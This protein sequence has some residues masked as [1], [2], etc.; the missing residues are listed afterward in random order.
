MNTVAKLYPKASGY[1]CGP[2]YIIGLADCE[3][4]F[5][6]RLLESNEALEVSARAT[7]PLVDTLNVGDEVLVTGD[8]YSSIYVT[9]LLA[10]KDIQQKSFASNELSLGNG[11]YAVVDD[12]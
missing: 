4:M 7:V 2:A 6:I 9:G 12:L 1:Y 5:R 8:I 10:T 11:A 3:G